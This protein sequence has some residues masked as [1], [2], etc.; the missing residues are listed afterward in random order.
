[1]LPDVMYR[2][3]FLYFYRIE[4][5]GDCTEEAKRLKELLKQKDAKLEALNVAV[6]E[7]TDRLNDL[8]TR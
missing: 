6:Q 1:M 3:N 2:T 8:E 5:L 4:S 7:K